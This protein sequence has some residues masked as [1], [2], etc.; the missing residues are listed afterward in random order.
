M[1]DVGS[2]L[3]NSTNGL[4]YLAGYLAIFSV[5][6]E[7][8]MVSGGVWGRALVTIITLSGDVLLAFKS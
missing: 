2:V 3:Q 1:R 5:W 8:C 4:G 7:M 6:L